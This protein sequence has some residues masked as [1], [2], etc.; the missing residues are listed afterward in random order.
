MNKSIFP[1]QGKKWEVDESAVVY[2]CPV[3]VLLFRVRENTSLSKY[4]SQAVLHKIPHGYVSSP[5]QNK[6]PC[7][8][9]CIR[10][11]GIYQLPIPRNII[12]HIL[13]IYL[14]YTNRT[15]MRYGV[16]LYSIN[17]V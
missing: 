1:N 5:T 16:I 6:R 7:V 11:R 15:N 13:F 2:H 8:C 9:I 12:S 4:K 10:N 3:W 14:C 17:L